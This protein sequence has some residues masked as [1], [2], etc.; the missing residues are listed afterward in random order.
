M[1]PPDAL[2]FKAEKILSRKRSADSNLDRLNGCLDGHLAASL[3]S[4]PTIAVLT[5]SA[6]VPETSSIRPGR[7]AYSLMEWP[8]M[9]CNII[10]SIK[11]RRL[12]SPIRQKKNGR[13]NLIRKVTK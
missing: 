12:F 4:I 3:D 1:C 13:L 9:V 6:A 5:R 11:N 10:E 8:G 7:H 2:K